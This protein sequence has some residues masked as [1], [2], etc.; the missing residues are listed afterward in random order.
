MVLPGSYRVSV[1]WP[2]RPIYPKATNA[3]FSVYDG[4]TAGILLGTVL[5]NQRGFAVEHDVS[6][7]GFWFQDLDNGTNMGIYTVTGNTLTVQLT[8]RRGSTDLHYRRCRQS[9]T[10]AAVYAEA[11]AQRRRRLEFELT[12]ADSRAPR[13]ACHRHLDGRGPER[14][15]TAE[16]RECV[17]RSTTRHRAGIGI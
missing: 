4:T 2:D 5:V 13:S 3:P 17:G 7:G 10:V 16:Q 9:R 15:W 11:S 14:A 8:G 12:D 6:D 1:T